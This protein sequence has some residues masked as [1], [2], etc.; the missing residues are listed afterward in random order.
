MENEIVDDY[1][2][3]FLYTKTSCCLCF[4]NVPE[5]EDGVDETEVEKSYLRNCI[6]KSANI[7]YWLAAQITRR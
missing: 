6:K 2:D 3:K 5:K 4:A 1:I 7:Q